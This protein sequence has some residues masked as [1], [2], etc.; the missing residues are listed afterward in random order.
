MQ[1]KQLASGPQSTD[2]A[3]PLGCWLAMVVHA[4]LAM[5]RELSPTPPLIFVLLPEQW[6]CECASV[7]RV[8]GCLP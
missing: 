8:H 7:L 3:Q 1:G 4:R 2:P 6:G 5:R